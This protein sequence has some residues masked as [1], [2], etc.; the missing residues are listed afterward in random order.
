MKPVREA[1]KG[2]SLQSTPDQA[3][4]DIKSGNLWE[5]KDFFKAIKKT[6]VQK[7]FDDVRFNEAV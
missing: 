5:L 2:E 6:R 4:E 1:N 3:E 7:Q